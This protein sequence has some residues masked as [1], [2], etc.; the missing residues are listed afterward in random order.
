QAAVASALFLPVLGA[1]LLRFDRDTPQPELHRLAQEAAIYLE[2]GERVALLLPGDNEDALGSY[3][4]GLLLFSPPRRSGLDF[5][6]ETK[7]EP[8]TLTSIAAAGYRA[9][10]VTCA[11]PGFAGVP[12]GDAAILRDM[13]EGWRVL[14]TWAWPERIKRQRFA[15][16]LARQ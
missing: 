4:R 6:M 9:A 16:M 1:P 13:P 7:V 11:P 14:R 10:L 12:A 15:A 5:R 2:S 8:A 3:L